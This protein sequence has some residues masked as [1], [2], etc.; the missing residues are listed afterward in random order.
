MIQGYIRYDTDR[1]ALFAEGMKEHDVLKCRASFY[2][3][4]VDEAALTLPGTNR[5]AR[6]LLQKNAI[7]ELRD[8]DEIVFIGETATMI[9]DEYGDMQLDLDGALG[10][11][12]CVVK[13]P[14]SIKAGDQNSPVANFLA[15]IISQYNAGV[16]AERMITLGAV[17]ISGNVEMD[18]HD[19]YTT[20][21]QLLGE[22]RE[23][24]GGYVYMDYASGTPTLN[25]VARPT[26]QAAQ[27]LELGVNV[28]TV[29]NQL[30]FTDYASRVYAT[31]T[32]YVTT[33]DK[34][35]QTPLDAG[36]VVDTAAE[37][38]YGRVDVAYKSSTD[39]GGDQDNNIPDKTQQEAR[40][41]ILAEAQAILDERKVPLQ[42][43]QLTATDL[44]Q[45]G[46]NY[47][48]FRI[49]TVARAYL[50]ALRIDTTLAVRKIERDYIDRDDSVVHFGREAATISGASFGGG[51]VTYSGGGSGGEVGPQ[52]P[53]GPP[54][55]DGQD[56]Q[57]GVSPAVSV[58]VIEGGHRVTITTATGDRTF[59]VLD[60]ATGAA[61]QNGADGVSPTVAVTSITGGHRVTITDKSHP[62]GISFDVMDGS[63]AT[64]LKRTATIVKTNGVWRLETSGTTMTWT[65][66]WDDQAENITLIAV[67]GTNVQHMHKASYEFT[68][69]GTITSV[70]LYFS[71]QRYNGRTAEGKAFKITVPETGTGTITEITGA[72]IPTSGGGGGSG[73]YIKFNLNESTL[74]VTDSGGTAATGR[75]ILN[76]CWSNSVELYGTERTSSSLKYNCYHLLDDD[77]AD[78]EFVRFFRPTSDGVV[79][80][81]IGA[82]E[83]TATKTVIPYSSASGHFVRIDYNS[84]TTAVT[85]NG[86]AIT[87]TQIKALLDQ[88]DAGAIMVDTNGN[89]NG[90]YRLKNI[91]ANG[92]VEFEGELGDVVMN[93]VVPAASSTGNATV[94]RKA[95]VYYYLD[96][97]TV[98]SAVTNYAV[99]GQQ[100]QN[101]TID[102]GLAPIIYKY[103][104]SNYITYEYH[105]FA[106][107]S[108]GMIFRTLDGK[109]QIFL[110]WDSSTAT[111]TQAAG[112]AANILFY[113]DG[114]TV[115]YSGTNTAVT[116]ADVN[117]ITIAVGIMPVI[118]QTIN[119]IDYYFY[120]RIAH[121]GGLEFRL[122]DGT[123]D[124]SLRYDSSTATVT[125]NYYAVTLNADGTVNTFD[126]ALTYS[127]AAASVINGNP[128]KLI[129]T[130]GNSIFTADAN[131]KLSG[132]NGDVKFITDVEHD[133][134]QRHM[135]FTLTSANALQ[136][137]LIETYAR[138][139][140]VVW[141]VADVTQGL[142]ALNTNISSS[143]AWQL[144]GLNLAPFKR[145]KV[146]VKAGRKT[147]IGAADSSITPASIIEM[148]LDD[149]AKE[150]VSQNVFIGSSVVQ[151]PNDPNR[152]GVITCAV[153]GDKTKF[154]VVR[155]TTLYGTAAT[156]NTDAYP[157]VFKIEGY[158]D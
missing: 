150:T 140:S 100:I 12:R 89:P 25:Y 78:G 158:Y 52:G 84:N 70:D 82:A 156:S 18:H 23:Q 47:R 66:L 76:A 138:V 110:G 69:S 88:Q 87:G 73:S 92:D 59:D 13:P 14:F 102:N 19:E 30:D 3:N 91:Y 58:S 20:M 127:A 106:M 118:R 45:I 61:G 64:D 22:V 85:H 131:E 71:N 146:Y 41:I 48:L 105:Y 31:G 37:E 99:T 56:G 53:P 63:S 153:S 10:W 83:T 8:D 26:A 34:R 124:L 17:T 93:V 152:L 46:V 128:K 27:E 24:L 120:F 136:T 49:G 98:K 115:K 7:V 62:S 35:E 68:S 38:L 9:Q 33:G 40:E 108:G 15:A 129:V 55:A 21:L 121:S 86:T 65:D 116:G 133:G 151:N 75:M 104:S 60:G 122:L 94:T 109:R 28:L 145:I 39:M 142:I 148:S 44:K 72:D 6:S 11:L 134:I 107:H 130:W 125:I 123:K 96:G 4:E 112:W 29:E 2:L 36:Y 101:A 77:L 5:P 16:G 147:G 95:Q 154:A 114:T 119:G 54:G 144:T 80:I 1:V 51:S 157:Y 81:K 155:A 32:Y 137:T 132:A 103:E 74:A 135:I 97:T 139:P 79:V 67:D 113:L 90:V 57:D 141:E 50:R 43:L 117:A 111:I 126:S 143:L 149:R 42:S